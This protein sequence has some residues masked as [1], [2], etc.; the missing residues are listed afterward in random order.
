MANAEF[1]L[2]NV[3]ISKQEIGYGIEGSAYLLLDEL[4][5]SKIDTK[6]NH[7]AFY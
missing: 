6:S 7:V 4:S 1:P 5:I 2:K 3:N